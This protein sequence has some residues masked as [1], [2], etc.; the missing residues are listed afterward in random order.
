[1]AKITISEQLTLKQLN[2]IISNESIDEII[3][4]IENL[5]YILNI[6]NM[7]YNKKYYIK[8]YSNKLY[9]MDLLAKIANINPNIYIIYDYED[10]PINKYIYVHKKIDGLLTPIKDI[11]LSP[12]EKYIYI[13]YVTSHIKEY[14]FEE[15]R[16]DNALSLFRIFDKDNDVIV[17]GAYSKLLFELSKRIIT[18][19]K[20]IN[21]DT[22]ELSDEGY[23]EKEK[24]VRNISKIV[25]S[26]YNI[27]GI[28]I[29][30]ATWG[31]YMDKEI[32]T[33]A[34]MTPLESLGTSTISIGTG[35]EDIFS[36]TTYEEFLHVIKKDLY[37]NSIIF[38][39][40]L[41]YMLSFYPELDNILSANN[42][43]TY[44]KRIKTP[45]NNDYI[46]LFR[47][48][49]FMKTLFNFI[50]NKCNNVIDGKTIINAIVNLKRKLNPTMTDEELSMYEQT[51][52][53][54]N[55][56]NYDELFLVAK[57]YDKFDVF[58]YIAGRSNKF[59]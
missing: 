42:S 16:E 18:N 15:Y 52:I 26:K 43:Y 17:C 41:E 38:N 31:N 59:K 47:D 57:E 51:I 12:L 40:T 25:D 2:D 1:M 4:D 20:R 50:Y 36:S 28:Y 14:K 32:Y 23:L 19:T 44:F 11:E 34:L 49:N 56:L 53:N 13:Y 37:N 5:D 39:T 3:F 58:E 9:N 10:V 45:N 55:Y 46:D 30:D 33:T 35:I 29:S 22:Y 48:D 24:H 54:D 7:F 8:L 21:I 6:S 27:D